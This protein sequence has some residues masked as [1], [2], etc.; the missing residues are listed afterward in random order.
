MVVVRLDGVHV[1]PAYDLFSTLVY[2]CQSRDVVHV[3][4]DGR[5]LVKDAELVT[6]DEREVVQRAHVEAR[7][8]GKNASVL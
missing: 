4:V 3:L 5:Q 1:A 6:L 8:M 7:R 2:A